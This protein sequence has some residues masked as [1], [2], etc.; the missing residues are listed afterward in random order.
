[1][2]KG[3]INK[4]NY[5]VYDAL[6]N[7]INDRK[8]KDGVTYEEGLKELEGIIVDFKETVN[9]ILNEV[10]CLCGEKVKGFGHNP[11]PLNNEGRCCDACNEEVI[12]ARMAEL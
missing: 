5:K 2:K 10:C 4:K 11:A 7:Y 1:M 3:V 8:I 9:T 12:K 6:I